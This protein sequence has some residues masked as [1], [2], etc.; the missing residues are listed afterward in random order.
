ML[1]CSSCE[2]FHRDHRGRVS[3]SCDPFSNIKEP[4]CLTKL[5][6]A[7]TME[8]DRK[9]ERLVN[10]Y[11]ATLAIYRK[12]QP[13]QEKMFEHME[14]EIRESE[15]GDSWKYGTADDDEDDPVDPPP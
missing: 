9:L 8:S 10:A 11:E 3:F 6:L 13:L 15:E 2:F 4:E 5:T 12:M 7:R 1:Q 14:R